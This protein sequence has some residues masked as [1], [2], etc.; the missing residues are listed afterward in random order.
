MKTYED[1]GVIMFVSEYF[2]NHVFNVGFHMDLL[3]VDIP[4]DID[5]SVLDA[6]LLG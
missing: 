1:Y 3:S 6:A 5:T 2:V 4:I